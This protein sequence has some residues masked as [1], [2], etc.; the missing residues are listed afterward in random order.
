MKLRFINDP[1]LREVSEL[2]LLSEL[3]Y[4]KSLIP[5]MVLIMTSH[6]GIGLAANQVGI[7]KRFFIFKDTE[8]IKL[9]INPEILELNKVE[10]YQEGCLSIPG[11]FANTERATYVK[12]KFKDDSFNDIVTEYNGLQAIA[13]QHEVDHLNGKLYI[14]SLTYVKRTMTLSKY[15][16]LTKKGNK[17]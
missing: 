12:L 14:D 9:I 17:R 8:E 4:I 6:K 7:L 2:V 15:G 3:D 1:S 11:V 10:T 13:I 5:E 16:K